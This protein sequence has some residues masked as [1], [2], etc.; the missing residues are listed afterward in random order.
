M[1]FWNGRSSDEF[2]L[3]VEAYPVRPVP[4]R[5]VTKVSVPGRSGDI[6]FPED[7]FENV[8]QPYTCYIS[9]ERQGLPLMATPIVNW[10]CA[11]GYHRLEDSYN[12]GIYRM[13]QYTGGVDIENILNMFGRATITFDCAPQRWLKS[14][15]IIKRLTQSGA[16][17]F[18]PTGQK[19]LPLI[20]VHGS[21]AGALTV[22]GETLNLTD[23]NGVVLDFSTENAYRGSENMNATVTGKYAGLGDGESAISWTGGITAIDIK[24]RW[25]SL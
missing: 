7:A 9:A 17:L 24:P 15:E 25:W 20:S 10:L 19:A 2:G 21:G 11:P 12:P 14:G 3:I 5:K 8:S 16:V 6:V 1:I 18:N 13:A 23:C 22:G 4:R